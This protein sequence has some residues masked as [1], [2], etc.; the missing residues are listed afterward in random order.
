MLVGL[1]VGPASATTDGWRCGHD[2]VQ[3]AGRRVGN[4]GGG[5]VAGQRGDPGR[6]RVADSKGAQVDWCSVMPNAHLSGEKQ[7]QKEV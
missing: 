5:R 2:D 4:H 1:S 3:E 6:G 7:P